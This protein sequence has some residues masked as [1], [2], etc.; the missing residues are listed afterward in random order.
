MILVTR[1]EKMSETPT[2]DTKKRDSKALFSPDAKEDRVY[3]MAS[4]PALALM[5][6]QSSSTVSDKGSFYL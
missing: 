5:R 2:S 1:A 4:P 6:T 3:W